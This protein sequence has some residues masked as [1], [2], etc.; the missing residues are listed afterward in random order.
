MCMGR[1]F[2]TKLLIKI[3]CVYI[4]VAL[5]NNKKDKTD[6][7]LNPIIYYYRFLRYNEYFFLRFSSNIQQTELKTEIKYD[8]KFEKSTKV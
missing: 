3:S 5:V 6:S 4:Y 7:R 8:K 2:F 1:V